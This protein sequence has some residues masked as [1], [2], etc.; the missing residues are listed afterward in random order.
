MSKSYKLSITLI[1]LLFQINTSQ[2]CGCVSNTIETL[3][4]NASSVFTGRIIKAK[5]M[6]GSGGLEDAG[7]S[8]VK[9]YYEI[10]K[11][12]K[13]NPNNYIPVIDAEFQSGNCSVGLTIS[14]K[15]IFFLDR[16][17]HINICTGTRSTGVGYNA[18]IDL[19]EKI[20]K[21]QD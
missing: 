11:I 1:L 20:S 14:V 4:S 18:Y 10:F 7:E 19:I 15:Y 3:Y 6:P 2:A 17:S 8:H 16:R 5:M 12:Y 21:S 9:G 13:G